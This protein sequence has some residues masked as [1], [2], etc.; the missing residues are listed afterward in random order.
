MCS[1]AATESKSC[2]LTLF[3][4][5]QNVRIDP[6]SISFKM[7]KDIPVP[8]YMSMYFFEVLNPDQVLQGAKPVLH[9]RGPYV[10]R[11]GSTCG[12]ARHEPVHHAACQASGYLLWPEGI[13]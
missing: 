2:L 13:G 3:F 6:G 1:A 11:L 4:P 8:F 9:Q 7:W 12:P 10:Y 5:L